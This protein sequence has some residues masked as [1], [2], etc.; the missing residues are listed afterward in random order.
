[1]PED[2]KYNGWT[3]Y[4]TWLVGLWLDNDQGTQEFVRE[5]VE[6]FARQDFPLDDFERRIGTTS[7][8]KRRRA[9]QEW[10]NDYIEEGAE[11]LLGESSLYS[12]LLTAALSEV[13]WRDLAEHYLDDCEVEVA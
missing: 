10:L 1:M 9:V 5:T 7:D 2:T 8:D 12:D 6:E 4:E 13:D 11:S 3:N